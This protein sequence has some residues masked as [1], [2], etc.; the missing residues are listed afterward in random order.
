[1]SAKHTT[2]TLSPLAAVI[3][4]RAAKRA[5]LATLECA[6]LTSEQ[7][8]EHERKAAAR[9][10]SDDGEINV[11]LSFNSNGERLN[12]GR[13]CN[14]IVRSAFPDNTSKT[15]KTLPH[16]QTK[17]IIIASV[18]MMRAIEGLSPEDADLA[19]TIIMCEARNLSLAIADAKGSIT[20]RAPLAG[21]LLAV[22]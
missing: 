13:V 21:G 10:A 9:A 14:E 19:R 12:V 16:A 3:A 15:G 2:P 6:G 7:I 18:A 5:V 17:A 1:M 20:E 4:D 8:A 22:R 11:A